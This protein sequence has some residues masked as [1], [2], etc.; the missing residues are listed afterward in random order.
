MVARQLWS[1]S[2]LKA[3]L[4]CGRCLQ[5]LEEGWERA[6]H[7]R[8][9]RGRA[10]H[11]AVEAWE[12]SER[13]GDLTDVVSDAWWEILTEELPDGFEIESVLKPVLAL[14]QTEAE[15]IREEMIVVEALSDQYKKPRATKAYKEQTAHLDD[16]RTETA[17]NRIEVE[18][19]IDAVEWPWQTDKGTLVEGLDHSMETTRLGIEY[20]TELWPEPDIVGAEWHLTADLGNGY[21]VHGYI[22]RVENTSD[23]IEVVDY[24]SSRFHDTVLDHW[25]Q[26]AVYSVIAEDHIGFA[27]KR[28]RLAYMRGQDSDVFE[29]KANWRERLAYLVEA[30]DQLLTS[31]SFAPSF[32][33]CGICGFFPV[34]QSEFAFTELI[35]KEETES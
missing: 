24:K 6:Q 23:G 27:P 3:A 17:K 10:V 32:A 33:G 16:A 25:L 30:A 26:A 14:W 35:T 12:K 2:R 20:L 9:I 22:D 7:I 34:C 1:P 18:A 13:T 28:V 11:G 15:I 5:G 31:K 29:V 19:L 21:R 8:G 4:Q